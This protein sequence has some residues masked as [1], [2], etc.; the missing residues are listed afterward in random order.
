MWYEGM[1]A[2]GMKVWRHAWDMDLGMQFRI[3]SLV[4]NVQLLT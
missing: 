4:I 2:C 1:E 3:M